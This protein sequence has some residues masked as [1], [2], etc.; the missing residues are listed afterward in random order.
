MCYLVHFV[1][2]ESYHTEMEYYYYLW[3]YLSPQSSFIWWRFNMC[4]LLL[5]QFDVKYSITWIMIIFPS[6]SEHYPKFIFLQSKL[7]KCRYTVWLCYCINSIYII[8]FGINIEYFLSVE[9]KFALRGIAMYF[10]VFIREVR[11]WLILSCT[12]VWYTL[13]RQRPCKLLHEFVCPFH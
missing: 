6:I 2:R 13:G 3:Q 8:M 9:Q 12:S 1:L 11:D 5:K 7:I 4:C 10:S